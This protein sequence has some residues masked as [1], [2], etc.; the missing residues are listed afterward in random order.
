MPN[1]IVTALVDLL[2][3]HTTVFQ[4][5]D[6]PVTHTLLLASACENELMLVPLPTA[7]VPNTVVAIYD[8]TTLQ[9]NRLPPLP[10]AVPNVTTFNA[11]ERLEIQKSVFQ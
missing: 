1:L 5:G 4:L 3:T 10:G 8:P 6:T 11:A 7:T 2:C 9:S